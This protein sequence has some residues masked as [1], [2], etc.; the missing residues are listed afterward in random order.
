MFVGTTLLLAAV[1]WVVRSSVKRAAGQVRQIQSD[2]HTN[3]QI[4]SDSP[5]KQL[6][7]LLAEVNRLLTAKQ[8]DRI[9]HERKERE[10]RKQIANITHDLRTPLTSML[11]Y[12]EL[13]QEDNLSAEETQEYL[14]IVENRTKALRSLISGFY[15]LARME[16][17]D[18]PV[19]LQ[20]LDLL[21]LLKRALADCYPEIS[22]AGFQ[23]VLDLPE[24]NCSVI[25]DEEIVMR[26]YMNLLQNVRKHGQHFMYLFQGVKDGRYVTILSNETSSLQEEDLPHLFERSFTADRSRTKHNTGLG[27]TIVQG[28]MQQMGYRIHAEYNAPLFTIHLEWD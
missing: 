13:L 7:A 10:I 14:T 15:D 9:R 6:E 3:R 5:D 4:R 2:L 17:Y 18:Y 20:K 24:G 1:Y 21:V 27:L 16:A 22:A 11:G 8:E 19:I 12:I 25:A 26:I 23:V 28:L